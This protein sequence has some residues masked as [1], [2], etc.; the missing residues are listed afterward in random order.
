MLFFVKQCEKE[1]VILMMKKVISVS[2]TLLMLTAVLHLS[3]ATHYCGGKEAATKI[4]L[5]GKLASCGMEDDA[6]DLPLTGSRIASHCCDNVLM[7]YGINGNFFP[8]FSYVPETYQHHFQVFSEPA[9]LNLH[10]LA[11][12]KSIYTSVSPPDES[13]FNSVD[14]SDICIFRI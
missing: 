12:V 13:V 4:S 3:V 8:S 7:I 6:K 9:G 1:S 14:L 11:S 2:L 10:S 5:S